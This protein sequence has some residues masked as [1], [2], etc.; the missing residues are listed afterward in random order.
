MPVVLP[1]SV[2]RLTKQ[3]EILSMEQ[4]SSDHLKSVEGSL[5]APE[6]WGFWCH[7]LSE[8]W[9]CSPSV[10]PF[11][12]RYELDSSVVT[13]TSLHVV[14]QPFRCRLA[15]GREAVDSHGVAGA[16]ASVLK[17]PFFP[18]PGV[19]LGILDNLQ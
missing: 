17:V 13:D 4:V 10:F 19:L 16:G 14:C 18:S 1:S 6:W 15:E 11:R 8:P 9:G 5:L 12:Q 2:S 7:S 3:F